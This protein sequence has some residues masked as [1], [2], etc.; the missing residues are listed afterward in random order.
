[1][2]F[3]SEMGAMRRVMT[4]LKGVENQPSFMAPGRDG[5]LPA[6]ANIWRK[7]LVY[8][9]RSPA[10]K[11]NLAEH[12]YRVSAAFKCG[13]GAFSGD[14]GFRAL[15]QRVRAMAIRAISEKACSNRGNSGE[16][17]LMP[18]L[19]PLRGRSHDIRG[20][21]HARTPLLCARR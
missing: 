1:M 13:P 6:D 14:A 16:Y 7:G 21:H 15:Y 3:S 11:D 18:R 20:L 19:A 5:Q 12:G 17:R 4:K 9:L 10:T 8:T 2:H